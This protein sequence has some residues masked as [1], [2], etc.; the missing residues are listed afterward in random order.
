VL[1]GAHREFIGAGSGRLRSGGHGE[2][3]ASSG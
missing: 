2:S 1:G 3:V